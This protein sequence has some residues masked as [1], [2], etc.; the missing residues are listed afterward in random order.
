VTSPLLLR[1]EF[2]EAATDARLLADASGCRVLKVVE[3]GWFP[4]R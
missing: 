2:S 3:E 4:R 1:D